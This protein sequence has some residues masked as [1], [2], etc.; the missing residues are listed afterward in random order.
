[1]GVLLIAS[2]VA[3]V[4]S[5]ELGSTAAR[6]LPAPALPALP[7]SRGTVTGVVPQVAWSDYDGQL[8]IGD[9]SGLT[10]RVVTQTDADPT[11]ALVA[12]GG[13]IFW[14]RYLNP[15][16]KQTVDPIL[17]PTVQ[18]FDRATGETTTLGPGSQVFAVLG[19][20]LRLRRD[21]LGGACRVLDGRNEDRKRSAP[22]RWLV[23]TRGGASRESDSCYGKW[24]FG[25]I[26]P[27]AGR[28]D[29]AETGPL[30]PGLQ[31]GAR[32]REGLEGDR[33]LH[34]GGGSEQL[35]RLGAGE[36]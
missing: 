12:V 28:K 23:P 3:V 11:A 4:V 35:D 27:R 9:L 18:R 36:L 5:I 20:I 22:P 26:T 33:E 13:A 21:Q 29:P 19:W 24:D 10:E 25:R 15:T 31:P 32:G 34:Q 1:M 14:A 2:V 16:P 17:N 30:G 7:A 6:H 8:H